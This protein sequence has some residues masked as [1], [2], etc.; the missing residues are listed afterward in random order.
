[1]SDGSITVF[2]GDV[3]AV[4]QVLLFQPSFI[5]IFPEGDNDTIPG[6]TDLC[7]LPDLEIKRTLT[8]MAEQFAFISLDKK[9]LF[10]IFKRQ[11]INIAAVV[12]KLAVLQVTS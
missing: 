11:S 2:Y 5:G 3:V 9:N 1:M 12:L 7:A 6:G 8:F 4:R 10:M